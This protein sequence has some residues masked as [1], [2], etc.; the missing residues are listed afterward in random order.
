MSI[1]VLVD[2]FDEIL[3]LSQQ[4]Q[5]FHNIERS[6]LLWVAGTSERSIS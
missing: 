4:N 2:E 6:G 3:N 1:V 5:A